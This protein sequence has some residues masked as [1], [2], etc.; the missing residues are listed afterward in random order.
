MSERA[1]NIR[2]SGVLLL[3]DRLCTLAECPWAIGIIVVFQSPIPNLQSL[4]SD[5]KEPILFSGAIHD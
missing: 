4:I 3:C 1:L 5:F 2:R